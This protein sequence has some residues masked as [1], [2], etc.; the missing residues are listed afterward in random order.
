LTIAYLFEQLGAPE[1]SKNNPWS[2]VGKHDCI[3][4]IIKRNLFLSSGTE[5]TNVFQDYLDCRAAGIQYTGEW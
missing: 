5:T 4:A 3:S 1:N 2:S